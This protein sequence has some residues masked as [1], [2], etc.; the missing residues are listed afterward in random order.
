MSAQEVE[1]VTV[2]KQVAEKRLKQREAMRLLNLSRRQVIRLVK[3]YRREG[4]EGLL[5]RQRGRASN[6]RYTEK[7]KEAIKEIVE[8]TYGDFGP[9]FAA[10]KLEEKHK[11]KV[12]KETL[13]QWMMGWGLWKAKRHKQVQIHQSRERRGCFG[14]LIQID[15]SPHDWFEGRSPKCCLLV[16]ID[17][18]TS[19][20]VG[21]RFEATET[22]AGYFNLAREY[23]ERHGI[24][25][26]FYSDKYGVF[27]VNQPE[28]EGECETQ[29][30]RVCRTLRIKLSC[31]NSP[32]AK[33][34]VERVNNTL[35]ERLVKEMRLAGINDMEAGNAFLLT[36][37]KD[38][39]DRFAVI[40]SSEVN[41]HRQTLPDKE[42]LD[43]IFSFQ[44]ERTLS[45][46]LELSYKKVIYQ[47]KTETMGYR[48][49]GAKVT[50][51]EDMAG[52]VKLLYKDKI[53]A[54]SCYQKAARVT[55]VVDTKQL[56]K[57]LDDV[58][59]SDGR[60]QGNKPKT[61]H[62]WRQYD[63]TARKAEIARSERNNLQRIEGI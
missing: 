40:P 32:Q 53:L 12:S 48:L 23:M 7:K 5:S 11:I 49:R 24:P 16:F 54:Y 19:Q 61:K 20:L 8:K 18:A 29:F 4:A 43:I 9:K 6:R 55:P 50:V 27:R 52:E 38:H 1:R 63:V 15:G 14:E 59:K 36:Y 56:N 39:N 30:G 17:D 33:G 45:K 28:A 51:C 3:G 41:A 31:A 60:S 46:N 2:I 62:P 58:I 37:M 35:Q 44:D 10:E 25:L 26:A 21:L 57:M 47:I 22:A 42:V 34:R 13:R